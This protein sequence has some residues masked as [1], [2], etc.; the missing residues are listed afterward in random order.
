MKARAI[1]LALLVLALDQW[2]KWLVE[3]NLPPLETA[4]VVPGFLQLVHV[5]NPG[6]AFGLFAS[7][8]AASSWILL[9]FGLAA[10]ALVAVYLRRARPDQ[11]L[12]LIALGL[13]LG[14][15]LG[16]LVDRFASGAVT[17]FV[18]VFVGAHHWPAFNVADSAITIALCLLVW[19][20][21]FT[22]Q[23]AAKT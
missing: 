14:G 1:L 22:R 9:L 4:I 2:T 19:D 15:A 13:V 16:N 8:G 3:T 12:L 11:T 20:A 17:D 18:D 6:V 21:F 23:P 7:A 10:L 5:R